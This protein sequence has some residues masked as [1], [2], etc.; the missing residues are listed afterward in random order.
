M[1]RGGKS[2]FPRTVDPDHRS[3]PLWINSGRMDRFDRL[4]SRLWAQEHGLVDEA[5]ALMTTL[6]PEMRRIVGTHLPRKAD[7]AGGEMIRIA[8]GR[9][10]A[11]MGMGMGMEGAH[12]R[13]RSGST[14]GGHASLEGDKLLVPGKSDHEYDSG[15]NAAAVA[16]PSVVTAPVD[17]N[18]PVRASTSLSS[19]HRADRAAF[20]FVGPAF[21][22]QYRPTRAAGAA[23]IRAEERTGNKSRVGQSD[24]SAELGADVESGSRYRHT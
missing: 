15:S 16:S 22:G 1:R 19:K 21:A 9:A 17:W 13:E 12:G 3:Q 8:G 11:G 7:E 4:Q 24:S 5:S 2:R 18:G 6:P 20:D 14:N 23:A 10:G